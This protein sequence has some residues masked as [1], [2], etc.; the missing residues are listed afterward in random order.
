MSVAVV[1]VP[2]AVGELDGALERLLCLAGGMESIVHPGDT[3][4]LK[5]NAVGPF[6]QAATDLR[7]LAALV[8]TVRR[9]GGLPV[10]A[11]SA[12]FEFDTAATFRVLGLERLAA[13]LNVPLYNLDEGPFDLRHAPGYGALP[14]ARIALEADVL[15]NVPKLK[16]HNLTGVTLGAKNL[17]GLLPRTARRKMHVRGIEMGIRGLAA[18]V[19]VSL[20]IVDALTVTPRAVFA[21]PLPLGLLIA[22][23]DMAAVDAACRGLLG[24]S[25]SAVA[26]TC[27][28]G[29]APPQPLSGLRPRGGRLYRALFRAMYWVDI[30]FS[31][32]SGGRS[33]IPWVHYYL[34]VRP[35]ID[36]Q[37]CDGCGVCANV[38]PVGALDP[39]NRRIDAARC[40]SLR[41]LR[42]REACP[43]GA[44]VLGGLRRPQ[45]L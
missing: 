33:L 14:V 11:E 9:C 21:R 44:I 8:R 37:R 3:V 28:L 19:P 45:E 31:R 23:C 35:A 17:M 27:E 20:T 26:W 36:R 40:M 15:I 6:P 34:G 39:T 32:L 2:G 43:R 25:A 16:L 1:R 5:P 12:G 38:C 42:C 10:I 41:C 18:A 29:A 24:F 13:Q 30:P 22:G 7:L 4:L